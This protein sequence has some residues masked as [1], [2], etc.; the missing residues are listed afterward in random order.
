MRTVTV[1][2]NW[3]SF[4]RCWGIAVP[5]VFSV[6]SDVSCR[7][8]GRVCRAWSG[9]VGMEAELGHS[10][11]RHKLKKHLLIHIPPF[12]GVTPSVE[13]GAAVGGKFV[14]YP[15]RLSG[16]VLGPRTQDSLMN[17]FF[18][19]F[20]YFCYI[21]MVS[22][23]SVTI[24]TRFF[25]FTRFQR[26]YIGPDPCTVGGDTGIRNL[27]AFMFTYF[28]SPSKYGDSPSFL[29]VTGRAAYPRIGIY[30][31]SMNKVRTWELGHWLRR[32]Y[33]ITFLTWRRPCASKVCSWRVIIRRILLYGDRLTH[34]FPSFSY[35]LCNYLFCYH[36]P[37]QRI[38]PPLLL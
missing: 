37:I 11:T 3:Y 32:N 10:L 25:W 29:R 31:T 27:P 38:P 28:G 9:L 33:Q 1:S 35:I 19:Y 6:P 12:Y 21:K 18:Y 13:R 2:H 17:T 34:V 26:R 4:P 8:R 20:L 16:P 15:A 22:N 14:W 36:L 30:E 24:T 23:S 5:T 7:D